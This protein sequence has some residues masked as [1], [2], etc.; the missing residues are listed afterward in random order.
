M[1]ERG[2]WQQ[3]QRSQIFCQQ[4]PAKTR[5]IRMAYME[6]LILVTEAHGDNLPPMFSAPGI[7]MGILQQIVAHLAFIAGK[8]H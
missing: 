2:R 6:V 1:L 8:Y 7:D 5:Q 4:V 3:F